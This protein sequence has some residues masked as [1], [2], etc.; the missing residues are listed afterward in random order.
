MQI[1]TGER[2]QSQRRRLGAR[3]ADFR[4][5]RGWSQQG[6]ANL[7]RVHRVRLSKWETG[8][9]SIPAEDLLTLSQAFGITADELLTGEPP[10][11]KRLSPEQDA[12]LKDHLSAVLNLVK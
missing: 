2:P 10:L 7:L 8:R 3:V 9:S 11:G 12:K 6:L 4:R 5:Q 1:A